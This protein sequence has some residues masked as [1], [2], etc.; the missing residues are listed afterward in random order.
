MGCAYISQKESIKAKD[1]DLNNDLTKSYY[2][3]TNET[4]NFNKKIT[5]DILEA[6]NTTTKKNKKIKKVK[7]KK[8]NNN[9]D[10]DIS[11]PIITLLKRQVE[12]KRK[13]K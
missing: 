5:G 3:E 11:G 6:N 7:N 8:N 12:N 13:R 1:I 9:E 4:I 2:K 10:I